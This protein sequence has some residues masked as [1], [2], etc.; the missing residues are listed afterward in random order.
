MVLCWYVSEETIGLQP[1]GI[2]V[3]LNIVTA[4]HTLYSQAC[5]CLDHF[6]NDSAMVILCNM[7]PQIMATNSPVGTTIVMLKEMITWYHAFSSLDLC[8]VALPSV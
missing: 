3:D 5:S 2:S 6:F 4:I 7:H 1:N 8:N